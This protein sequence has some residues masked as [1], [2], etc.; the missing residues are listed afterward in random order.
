MLTV[1]EDIISEYE[2]SI[3]DCTKKTYTI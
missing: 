2:V 1:R 3:L